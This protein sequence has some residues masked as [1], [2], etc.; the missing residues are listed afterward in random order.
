MKPDSKIVVRGARQ[1][2]LKGIT[3]EVPVGAVTVI[4]GVA[5]A[6]KSS[7]AFDVLHAEGHSRY[8]E[9]FSPYARQFLERLDRPKVERIDGVLPSVAIDRTAP[10][11]TSRST[12]GTMT[13]IA[14]YLRALWARASTLHCLRC[15]QPVERSS[16][17]NIFQR[18]LSHGTGSALVAFRYRVGAVGPEELREI[19][20]EAGFRR[21]L[22]GGAVRVIEEAALV[23][24]EGYVTVVLDRVSADEKTRQ[25]V[26]DSIES[27]MRFGEGRVELWRADAAGAWADVEHFTEH[28][29]CARC[30]I[31]YADPNAAL[32]SFNNPIGACETCKGFGRTMD[33]DPELVIP[34]PKLS[35]AEGCIKPFQTPLYQQSQL[36]LLRFMKRKKLRADV[37]WGALDAETQR[38]VFEGEPGG[39]EQWESRWYGV[40]GFFEWLESKTYKMHVRVLLSRYRRYLPC[41]A[42]K[43]SRLKPAALLFRIGG[44]TLP[45]VEAMS[46][47]EAERFFAAWSPKRGDVPTELLLREIRGRLKF[48][49]DVGLHYLTLSRQSRTLSGGEAQRVTL[50]T[51]LGSSLTKTLYVLDEPS[52]GLHARDAGRL[53]AVLGRLARAGN[54]VVV[55]EHD[56]VIISAADHVI[57]LGPGPGRAGGDVVYAGALP[58]L[59]ETPGSPTGEYLARRGTPQPV[60]R[61]APVPA[62]RIRV[63][64]ATENNLRDL[65]VDFP[66]GM[67]VCVTGV[68]GSGKSTLVD[69]ILHRN[70]RRH[71]G[72]SESE[73]GFVR[74]IDG[75]D[76]VRDVV[77]VDQEPPG[78]SSRMNAATYL[79]VLQPLRDVFAKSDEAKARGLE[80]GAFSF[81]SELGACVLCGGGGYEKVELQFLP[82]AYVKCPACDGRRFKPEVLEVRVRGYDIASLLDLPAE[83]VAKLFADKKKVVKAIQPLLDVGLGYL[84]LS[85]PAPTLSGG[86]AQRLKLAA[87]L[88]EAKE[89]KGLLYIFD[90]PTTGLHP[91]DVALVVAAIR[92][93]VDE[94]NS[95]IVVEHDMDV[96][97][98]SDWIIDLGPEGGDEGGKLVGEGTP[99]QLA[100][101]DTPTGRA[102]AV[103]LGVARDAASETLV[104]K[105]ASTS[106]DA[107]KG[108]VIDGAFASLAADA[109]RISGDGAIRILGAREHNLQGVHVELPHDKLVVVTGPSGSGKSTLAFDV[110]YAE[111]Q[112]RFL[113]CLPS[114]ARQFI[115]P[116]AR[117]EVDRV[118]GVPPTV[119]LEQR[120]SR[121]TPMSTVGTQSEVY[122][123]LRLLFAWLG[124]PH[125]P[126]C[127][128]AGQVGAPAGLAERITDD[129]GGA[130]VVVLAP[131]V[132]KKKG[133]HRE[134]I[135]KAAKHGIAEVRVDG[136]LRSASEDVSLDRYQLHDVEAVIDRVG[137]GRL[138]TE[139]LR[140]A[141]E[142]AL[143]LGDGIVIVASV[144]GGSERVYSMR[145]ACPSCGAGLPVPDPRLFTFSQTFGACPDCE[146][147]GAEPESWSEEERR[148]CESCEGSRLRPEARSVKIG[149]HDI[150]AIAAMN[151]REARRWLASLRDLP[152]E[153]LERVVPELSRRLELLEELGLGY[154]TLDRAT[155]TLATGEAQRIRVVAALATTLRG[156]CYVLDEP[157]V[158]LHPR[159]SEAL[160]KALVELRDRGNTVVVV[161]HDD[162]VIR[163]ADH[164]IDLGPGAGPHGGRI[165]AEGPPSTLASAPESTTGQ[166][167]RGLGARPA[168]PRRPLG[169]G[170]RLKLKGATLHNLRSLD[171]E[172][173]L[174]RLVCVTG[175][176]GSGKS[177]VV[178]DVFSRAV[179]D[180]LSGKKLPPVLKGIDGLTGVVRAL[181]VDE[182]PIGRTPRSVPATYV[183]IMDPI[184]TLFAQTPDARARGYAAGRFSFN[185]AG[186]RCEKC[187]GHGR[188]EVKMSLLPTVYVPCESCGGKRFNADTL[189][190]SFKGRSIA[191]VLAMPVDEAKELFAAF[192]LVRKPLELLSEIGLGYVQLGQP[193]PT[194]SG[195]EAQRIKL[196][197][198]LAKPGAGRAIIF[199][200]EPTTG[201]HMSDVAKLVGAL[202][203]FVD[204]G[205]T[206]VV[207]EHNLEVVAAADCV[208]DMGPESGADGG[209]VVA[210][211]TPEEVARSKRS[212]TAPYL[213]ETLR[214]A[215]HA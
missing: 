107:R 15:G 213:A 94:G 154:L 199:L 138:R 108:R 88:A 211:G 178:R 210:W 32:F 183:G 142:K 43:G 161:E 203:R 141:V 188:L 147:L 179:R 48:L 87:F 109:A 53:A 212:R 200:D 50:A 70:V 77:Y 111:G 95:V 51:A 131:L 214:R 59:L 116:L 186:G 105:G 25:R 169:E 172:I 184:R 92:R 148:T 97:A 134:L 194:L 187:E 140:A 162:G 135:A 49:L 136:E 17:A 182:S 31:P 114:Y 153:V 101:L 155:D 9:T 189:A 132:R 127:G 121:G 122:H 26:V 171:L 69:Q 34:D 12:V 45:D 62:A 163:S 149:K 72:Q 160:S 89:K 37:A 44:K 157:T 16:P 4:T 71:L 29:E 56:P 86:E 73:V 133:Q 167:L 195:G 201:L 11:R 90:E 206:V 38:L 209:Q 52:V 27:A 74:S 175:V 215:A 19:L 168:W 123:Y 165:V 197:A 113:D 192:P 100:R 128:T 164:V 22:E 23:H 191:D 3:A 85:Q 119:A 196:A 54:A 156:V 110:L 63:R 80:P 176:S 57:E 24:D 120:L 205:D 10:V 64:G 42:C 98:L 36:D 68:S 82:D 35:I 146:G 65:D 150:G 190:V 81:N 93:L 78:K 204:R 66:L 39:R 151:V 174:G 6:G 67:L 20:T 14:D 118:E 173:P 91:R 46:I 124:V 139:K 99:E 76:D 104:A 177:T 75:L 79:G 2:N 47:A 55:V 33:I 144:R 8:V 145:R 137:G 96:A 1:N 5:G 166:W 83:D 102:L 41:D 60:S 170:T 18:L 185:V 7:L 40:D 103:H 117:P 198:E 58:G 207:I 158:G 193:S 202:Q 30:Q 61:R 180:K 143:E 208:I 125:C 115:R 112:R 28:L 126:S 13:S 106:R 159:D 21:V 84:P 130:D 181:E 152:P 129:F